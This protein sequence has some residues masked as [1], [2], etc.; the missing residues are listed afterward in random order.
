MYSPHKIMES[1][2]NSVTE[3]NLKTWLRSLSEDERF[4]FISACLDYSG[5]TNERF[6]LQLAISCIRR[7]KDSLAI[8]RRGMSTSD[9]STIKF[10]LDFA[11]RKLGA[12][13][14][15]R[16]IASRIDTQP[17]MVHKA[18]YW[19]PSLVPKS[20]SK[21]WVQLKKLCQEK[22]PSYPSPE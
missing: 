2:R 21:A 6:A 22:K 15:I 11:I 3:R 10:W 1:R 19:L 4:Q 16:E 18:L 20:Q 17:N 12:K 8:L 5:C 7:K 13:A 9:A 14:V